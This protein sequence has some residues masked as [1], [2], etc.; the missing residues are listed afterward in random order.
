MQQRAVCPWSREPRPGEPGPDLR[1]LDTAPAAGEAKLTR[2]RNVGVMARLAQAVICL[3]IALLSVS[4]AGPSETAQ[5]VSLATLA[6]I[7]EQ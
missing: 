7:P 4:C 5:R 1:L 6:H 3:S 2:S